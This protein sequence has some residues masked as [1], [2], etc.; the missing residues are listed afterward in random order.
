MAQVGVEELKGGGLGNWCALVF[1]AMR[2]WFFGWTFF[3]P[4]FAFNLL[5]MF[6][7]AAI[8]YLM[9]QLVGPGVEDHVAQY[10]IGYGTYIIT[11]V[12]FNMVMGTTMDGYHQACMQSYW[13]TQ[14]VFYLQHPGGVSALLT[15]GVV[16]RYIMALVNTLIYMAVGSWLFGVSVAIANLFDVL[17]VL[18][19]A[20]AALTGL[21]L[22][23]ASTF[24]LLNAKQWGSNP[25]NWVVGFGVTLLSG[26]Y[27]PPAVL[28]A[29]LQRIGEWL[30]QT[31]VLHAARLCLSG[32][33]NLTDPAIVAEVVFLLKFTAVALPLGVALFAVGMRKAQRDGTLTRWT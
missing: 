28:P 7:S 27:F 33:A 31:H 24:T 22:A 20:V 12:M 16:M 26:V 4:S 25:V 1:F 17:A 32:R 9:G 19:L 3:L 23:G 8:F 11:G 21:G 5:G 15:G 13:A 2:N 14:F 30:P 29:W 10:G 6:T 18:V